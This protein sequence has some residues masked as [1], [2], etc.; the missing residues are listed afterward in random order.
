[1][2]GGTTVVSHI[3]H[4]AYICVVLEQANTDA[5]S[6]SRASSATRYD[7]HVAI[8]PACFLVGKHSRT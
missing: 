5:V 7:I 2:V 6:C 1:M 4:R 3:A 8:G